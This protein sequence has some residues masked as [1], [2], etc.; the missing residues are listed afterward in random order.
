MI[1]SRPAREVGPFDRLKLAAYELR[2]PLGRCGVSR[3]P[4]HRP[5]EAYDRAPQKLGTRPIS[6][7]AN[8]CWRTNIPSRRCG[9][10]VARGCSR[11]RPMKCQTHLNC[12]TNK[13]ANLVA[14]T[15]RPN[16]QRRAAPGPSRSVA[17]CIALSSARTSAS[18]L[19]ARTT[20]PSLPSLDQP[21]HEH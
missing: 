9:K 16:L 1:I 18:S 17:A 4:Y 8:K 14:D 7:F 13:V 11:A 2:R 12:L 20:M 15:I 6:F 10:A 3:K 21:N 5:D 19:L